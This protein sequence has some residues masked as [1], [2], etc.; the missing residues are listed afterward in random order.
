MLPSRVPGHHIPFCGSPGLR[1]SKKSPYVTTRW[2]FFVVQ[3]DP[4]SSSP[5]QSSRSKY[6]GIS[7]KNRCCYWR[8][9]AVH[10]NAC[11]TARKAGSTE[12]GCTYRGED[13]HSPTRLAPRLHLRA[14][15]DRRNALEDRSL[16]R[17]AWCAGKANDDAFLRHY[18]TPPSERS[19]RYPASRRSTLVGAL[20]PH[21]PTALFAALDL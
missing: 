18:R 6:C 1:G 21:S 3:G 20:S 17:F 11:A 5:H 8:A 12:A 14:F 10:R 2:G 9:T 7:R 19:A 4:E 15:R 13:E 16:E